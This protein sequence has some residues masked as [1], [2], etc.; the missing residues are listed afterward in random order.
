MLSKFLGITGYLEIFSFD[1][2]LD[3]YYIYIIHFLP[4]GYL[5]I[6]IFFIN[7]AKCT[8]RSYYFALQ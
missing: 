1:R 6:N 4:L 2:Y 3:E 7:D 8:M 5:K